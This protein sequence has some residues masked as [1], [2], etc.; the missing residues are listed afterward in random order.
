LWNSFVL[1]AQSSAM[2]GSQGNLWKNQLMPGQTLCADAMLAQQHKA[3][4]INDA[5]SFNR[6]YCDARA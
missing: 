6:R 2:Q 5:V 4:I 1:K 3:F